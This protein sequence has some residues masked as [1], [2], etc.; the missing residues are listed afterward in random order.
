[1]TESTLAGQDFRTPVLRRSFRKPYPVAVRGE[2]VYVWDA[3][4]NRYLD[5]SGSAAVNFI[6]HGVREV[7]D[8]MVEQAR[9]LEF[10]H[11]SQFTTPVAEEFAQELLDFAGE[12][13]RGGAVYFTCGGSESVETALKLARQYQV[14][15]GQSERHQILS[16]NQSYHGSTLGALSVSGNRKRREIY[17]PMVREFAHIGIPYCYR[18][19]FDCTDDCHN[20]GQQYAAELDSAIKASN[21]AAAGFIFE[22]MSGA[23]LGAVTPPPGYLQGIAEICRRHGVLLIADEV[24]T[25]MGRTGRNF[26]VEHWEVAADILV[27]AKGLSS[28]YAPLG[29]VI[30]SKKVVDAIANGSGAFLHGF[31]YNAHPVSVAAGRA[32]LRRVQSLN[33]V[34]AA[35]SNTEGTAGFALKNALESLRDLDS[36]GDVR[37]LGMLWAVEFVSNKKTKAPFPPEKNFAGLVGQACLR[38]GLLVYPMQGCVD[39]TTGDHLLIAPPAVI[40]DEQIGWAVQQ[41]RAAVEESA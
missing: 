31:T 16:R 18:C 13:F 11:T 22:P 7:S 5:F 25:G 17:L 27:A 29:A 35:D 6:G 33:L 40:A 8:A 28:G 10:V 12:H 9:Q 26:A 38:R 2:G 20:C 36:V 39:G 19:A 32:V 41:L 15:I 30:A 1:M 24:M 21:G 14:E 34:H 23:T 4:G 3:D 37:G